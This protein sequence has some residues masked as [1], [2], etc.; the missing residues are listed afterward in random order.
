MHKW[1][2]M[3]SIVIIINTCGKIFNIL[4]SLVIWEIVSVSLS[5]VDILCEKNDILI[6]F[7][8]K[9]LLKDLL[10]VNNKIIIIRQEHNTVKI[11]KL[12]LKIKIVVIP[13]NIIIEI[14]SYNRSAKTRGTDFVYEILKYFFR[15]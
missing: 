7:C 14:K 5:K 13:N 3:L 15:K 12:S 11:N 8:F 4:F 6:I 1:I 9:K 2:T 10:F